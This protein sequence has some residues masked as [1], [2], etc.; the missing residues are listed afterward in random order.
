MSIDAAGSR[1]TFPP[2]LLF[3]SVL[4]FA[5]AGQW[6]PFNLSLSVWLI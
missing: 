4:R 2:S 5:H 6:E 3:T 1:R